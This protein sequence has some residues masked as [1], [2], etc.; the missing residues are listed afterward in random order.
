M[1]VNWADGQ[2]GVRVQLHVEH[3]DH[4]PALV[5]ELLP[6]SVAVRARPPSHEHDPAYRPVV[7]M[8]GVYKMEYVSVELDLPE[9]A[10]KVTI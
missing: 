4:S 5:T 9:T 7:S 8:E 1:I 10:A 2:I 3:Q 6:S